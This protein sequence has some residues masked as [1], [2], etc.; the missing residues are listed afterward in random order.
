M[1]NL[2]FILLLFFGCKTPTENEADTS[3]CP[4]LD[5]CNYNSDAINEDNC[6]YASEGCLCSDGEDA[7]VDECSE[8]GGDNS[9]CADCAG[10]AN[11]ESIIYESSDWKIEIEATTLNWIS[12]P[13]SDSSN[14]LGV[15]S[16]ALDEQDQ[17]DLPE[18]P[19]LDNFI[20]LYFPHPEWDYFIGGN[21]CPSFT[22]D[23]KSNEICNSK[24][25]IAIVKS[26]KSGN[27]ELLFSYENVPDDLEIE[28]I[29]GVEMISISDG[30]VIDIVLEANIEKEFI[31][32]ISVN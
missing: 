25:W 20:S 9:T 26:E 11:G 19:S 1:S 3:G 8:C 27:V 2:L 32:K 23:Y 16:N 15:K 6:W 18:P 22:T 5:S 7:I 31:I 21:P 24:E 29:N 30:I 12:E 10:V 4:N 13:V 17:N 14:E 28:L